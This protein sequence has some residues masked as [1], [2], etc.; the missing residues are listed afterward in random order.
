MGQIGNPGHPEVQRTIDGA[1]ARIV[2][3]G[4][5]AGT[6]VNTTNVERYTK[7]GVRALMTGFF[8]WI[9]AGIKELNERAAA[10]TRG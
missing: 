1:I 9:Q 4:R 10:G 7:L 5:V 6:L 8:P 2:Q 3:A